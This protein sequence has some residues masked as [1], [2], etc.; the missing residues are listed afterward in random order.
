MTDSNVHGVYHGAV[1]TRPLVLKHAL[2]QGGPLNCVVFIVAV[3]ISYIITPQA[4]RFKEVAIS[5]KI[6][7]FRKMEDS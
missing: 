7:L 6:L 5:S 2:C 3:A 1:L 4:C